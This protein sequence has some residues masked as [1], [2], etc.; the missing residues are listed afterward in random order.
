MDETNI[1]YTRYFIKEINGYLL[2]HLP[3]S[4][5]E[6]FHWELDMCD[7]DSDQDTILFQDGNTYWSLIW[8]S[9]ILN[10][11]ALSKFFVEKFIDEN[12][13]FEKYKIVVRCSIGSEL[14]KGPWFFTKPDAGKL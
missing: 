12:Q 13:L 2:Y 9:G 6:W 7:R 5:Y 3:K 14:D 1:C 10:I 4:R 11:D 8:Y